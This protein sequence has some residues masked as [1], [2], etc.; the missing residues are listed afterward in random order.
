MRILRLVLLAVL[1]CTSIG[2]AVAGDDRDCALKRAASLDMDIDPAGR[3][4]VPIEVSGHHLRM[5]VDTGGFISALSPEVTASLGAHAKDIPRSSITMLNGDTITLYAEVNEVS[6]GNL[7]AERMQFLVLPPRHLPT[8]VDGIL[9]RT[10]CACTTRSSI[11]PR[12][13]STST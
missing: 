8:G 5:L 13:S 2:S 6:I 12:P 11:S 3:I 10:F 4:M 1:A 7:H 9:G